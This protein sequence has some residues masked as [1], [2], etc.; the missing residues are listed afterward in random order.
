MED[1]ILIY[2]KVFDPETH[3]P[4]MKECICIDQNLHGQLQCDRNLTPLPQWVI[5][6]HNAELT[7]FCMLEN[8]PNYIQYMVE[9]QPYSILKDLQKNNI[10]N[11]EVIFHFL[12]S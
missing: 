3:F 2:I 5:H 7:R 1:Y 9:G 6:S 4:S 8:F 11:K 12:Q 10:I